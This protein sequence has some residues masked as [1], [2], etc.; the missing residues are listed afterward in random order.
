MAHFSSKASILAYF[1]SLGK[2]SIGTQTSQKPK[3]RILL[4]LPDRSEQ[5]RDYN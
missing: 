1:I 5:A 2:M 3:N 4:H